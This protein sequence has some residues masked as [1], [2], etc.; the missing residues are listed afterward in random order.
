VSTTESF[1]EALPRIIGFPFKGVALGVLIAVMVLE[2]LAYLPGIGIVFAILA[3][4]LPIKYGMEVLRDTAHGNLEA[5]EFAIN[6]SDVVVAKSVLLAILCGI[7]AVLL[8][9]FLHPLMGL[10]FL[11]LLAVAMPVM[12]MTL[13]ID[14]SLRR[15]IN[16]LHWGQ[17]I[18][19][20]G[21]PYFAAVALLA[22]AFV[23]SGLLSGAA[24]LAIGGFIAHMLGA[25]LCHL[26]GWLVWRH[27]AA[28]GFEVAGAQMSAQARF[29]KDD[30]LLAAAEADV[31]A[32]HTPQA[33][34][35]I[36]ADMQERAVRGDVHRR[37][38]ELLQA[39]GDQAGLLAHGRQWLHQ[40]LVEKDRRAAV[41]LANQCFTLDRDFT[42]LTPDDLLEVAEQAERSGLAAL[43][44]HCLRAL[45]RQGIG[46]DGWAGWLHDWVQA[47][48]ARHDG[49]VA[50]RDELLQL[51][52]QCRKAEQ[53]DVV[54]GVLRELG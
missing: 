20:I 2:A 9:I 23:I 42:A 4:L 24:N 43:R 35:R 26:L 19:T 3:F 15:A 39:S 10:A 33:I 44:L 21:A 25:F 14:E 40:L 31:A 22:V 41:A 51:K 47:H 8:G 36:A 34:A 37:Y 30:Q 13:A 11:G 7:S 5:P 12:M 46:E 48:R 49:V 29:S 52:A 45:A 17:V 18:A 32:G 6:F 53:R 38:R 28:L 16:P 54:D 50:L 27:R 1:G